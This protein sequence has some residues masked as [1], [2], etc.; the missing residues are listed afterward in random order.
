VSADDAPAPPVPG[1]AAAK[2]KRGVGF[3]LLIAGGALLLLC[4]GG[5]LLLWHF[6]RDWIDIAQALEGE[7]QELLSKKLGAIAGGQV[8]AVDA[9][10]AA[11]DEKRDDDAWAMTAARFREATQ[12]EKFDGL[13]S[14]VRTV[15][16]RCTSKK[17]R[18]LNTR[19]ALGGGTTSNLVFAATFEKGDGTITVDLEQEAG[20]WKVLGWRTNSPLFD[21]AMKRGAAK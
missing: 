8:P 20:V 6:G 1:L 13:T 4:G 2:K 12:R 18:N 10:V 7:R 21:E 16:G 15:M 14:L 9:F 3:W 5:V 17:L 11:V 19:Q